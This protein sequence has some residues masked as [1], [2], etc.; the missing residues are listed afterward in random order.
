[1]TSSTIFTKLP[2]MTPVLSGKITP[3]LDQLN[4]N[5]IKASAALGKGI[6]PLIVEE[7]ARLL[8]LINSYFTN[9]MEGN[10]SKLIDIEAALN[11]KFAKDNAAR[12]YQLEHVAHIEV[13]EAMMKRLR[14]E[15]SLKICSQDFLCWLHEQFFLRL[16]EEMRF[17]RTISGDLVPVEPGRLRDRGMTVGRHIGPETTDE[18]KR[19]LAMFEE[20]L[21]PEKLSGHQR[22]LGMASSHHRFLWIHPFPEGNGRVARLFTTA[23]GF[24][25][26]VGDHLLW[27]VTRAFARNRSEYDAHLALAD[28]PRRNDLDG[29]GPLSEENLFE[30]C[31]YFLECCEDQIGYMHRLL[32]LSQLQRRYRLYLDHRVKEKRLSKAGAKVMDR[33]LLQGEIPR[34]EVLDICRVKQRRATQIIKE[35]LDAK[36]VRCETSYGPLRLSISAEMSGVLFPTL[37]Q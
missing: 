8:V 23:Y 18:I 15:P 9:A 16:P 36:I 1:M 34:S 2:H 24:R 25:I 37:A 17:A 7:I 13:Q 3:I 30:W 6:H 12:N 22:L 32:N 10:P 5:V 14:Q 27:M 35:L 28:Q 26:G 31:K 20:L 4:V 29:R 21:S 11:H 19:Y 33:L